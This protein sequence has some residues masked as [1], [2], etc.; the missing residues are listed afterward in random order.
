MSRPT[1]T[2]DQPRLAAA[3]RFFS[4]A[5]LRDL[6]ARGRSALFAQLATEASFT[7]IVPIGSQIRVVFDTAFSLLKTHSYNH[8][9]LYKAALAHKVLLGVHSLRT[10]SMMTELR[11]GDCRADVVILNGTSTA[12]EIK[13][14]RDTLDRLETQVSTYMKVFANVN[15]LAGKKYLERVLASVPKD[16]GVMH[17]NSQYGISTIRAPTEDP[18][19]LVPELVFDSLQNSEATQI[20]KMFGVNIPDVPNTQRHHA[21]RKRFSRLS[22]HQVHRGFLAVLRR[23]RDLSSLAQLIGELPSSLCA[24]TLATPPPKRAY[25]RYIAAMDTPLKTALGWAS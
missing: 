15:I 1:T 8:E 14:D 20:L 11:V 23:T 16:V 13:S 25:E 4:S 3:A 22:P 19:R 17:L 12:Y 5:V 21:L 10:A 6:A 24:A 18:G 7:D 9:Y 2:L